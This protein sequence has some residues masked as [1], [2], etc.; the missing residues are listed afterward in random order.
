MRFWWLYTDELQWP[1]ICTVIKD[2]SSSLRRKHKSH[3]QRYRPGS[4][5]AALHLV[6]ASFYEFQ[7]SLNL[8]TSLYFLPSLLPPPSLFS[9]TVRLIFLP[10]QPCELQHTDMLRCERYLLSHWHLSARS[11]DVDRAHINAWIHLDMRTAN[12]SCLGFLLSL[13]SFCNAQTL[14]CFSKLRVITR[15][16]NVG[17]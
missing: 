9:C 6:K 11:D 2:L 1:V 4:I 3:L 13:F 16:K 7:H 5:C 12:Q 14:L 15:Q 8:N 17:V 10:A